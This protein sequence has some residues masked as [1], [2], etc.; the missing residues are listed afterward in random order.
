MQ[1]TRSTI[2]LIAA[3][4]IFVLG[5]EFFLAFWKTGLFPDV[6]EAAREESG[7]VELAEGPTPYEL[8]TPF[9]NQKF[10]APLG[11]LTNGD[12]RIYIMEQAGIVK[13]FDS[14]A[15]DTPAVEFVNIQERVK[16]GGE[17]GLL[18]MA[19]HPNYKVNGEVF[20]HYSTLPNGDTMVSRFRRKNGTDVLD[21]NSEEKLLSVNQPYPNHNGGQ[22]AFGPDGYLYIGL[23]DGGSGGDPHR[24]AKNLK[25]LLGKILRIDVNSKTGDL[26]YGIPSDNPFA[27]GAEG[28]R[29]EIYAYG[30]RNPW[31]FSFDPETKKLWAAD[32]GQDKW[33]EVDIIEKG[34][35]YGWNTM[36][37]K[38]CYLPPKN[39]KA[40]GLEI[41]VFDYGRNQGRSV[42]GGYI[43]R[44]RKM[45]TQV[46][47]Y[48]YGD[49][50]SGRIWSLTAVGGQTENVLL[51]HSN[52][53]ISSFGVDQSGEIY[54]TGYGDGMIY[55]LR[56]K[57]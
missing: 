54:V 36:E 12:S 17:Q 27:D 48:I 42:T 55:R 38:S 21:P 32:V 39:C 35:D 51:V 41:P 20:L 24:N 50:V 15:A 34:K 11:F 30:L 1:K 52:V 13:V 9:P 4:V 26:P 28:K 53:A 49:F 10:T 23:G 3:L 25:T 57:F 47:H 6:E 18:G 44:G 45:Y 5:A 40:K 29:G 14:N 8:E 37:G 2:R 31:R 33:E 16:S 43:Y 46:G 7:K 19:F 22:L 56:Q